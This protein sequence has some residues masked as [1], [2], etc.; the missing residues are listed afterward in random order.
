MFE[1]D[2]AKNDNSKEDLSE[3]D[4]AAIK[5]AQQLHHSDGEIEIDD[6]ALVSR[7]EDAGCYVQAW[8]WVAD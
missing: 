2:D 5:K 7:G 6:N 4:I 8:V 3:L 1:N